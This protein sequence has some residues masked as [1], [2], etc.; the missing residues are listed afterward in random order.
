MVSKASVTGFEVIE[1]AQELV[2]VF[3]VQLGL[4]HVADAV[5]DVLALTLPVQF[6]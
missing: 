5:F 3:E 1:V 4:E 2:V 6:P